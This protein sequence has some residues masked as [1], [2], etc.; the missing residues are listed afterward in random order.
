M[1]RPLGRIVVSDPR[2]GR[3]LSCPTNDVSAAK[4]LP[5]FVDEIVVLGSVAVCAALAKLPSP[6][7]FVS[8]YTVLPESTD[9][10]VVVRELA[11]GAELFGW[12]ETRPRIAVHQSL[13]VSQRAAAPTRLD[14]PQWR[15]M[16]GYT[17][18]L[19]ELVVLA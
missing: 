16:V 6:T 10:E 3:A 18:T 1:L 11:V 19:H 17:C 13:A 15:A 9:T 4:V 14:Q 12:L 2:V 8:A 7:Q 5:S